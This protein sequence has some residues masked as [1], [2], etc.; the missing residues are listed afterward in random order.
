MSDPSTA[1][2]DAAEADRVRGRWRSTS[3]LPIIGGTLL[4]LAISLGFLI[5]TPSLIGPDEPFH[6]DRVVA[7]AHGDL[8]QDA[9]ELHVSQGDK[10]S[11]AA[12]ARTQ[13]TRGAPSWAEYRP[14]PRDQ[15]QSLNDLGGNS[16]PTLNRTNYLT[17][18][19]P[20]YYDLLGGVMWLLP[21]ADGMAV[22]QL[23]LLL[24]MVNVLIILALPALFW[25]AAKELFGAGPIAAAAAY[26]PALIP[27]IPRI[28]AT[29]NND[30][31]CIVVGAAIIWLCLRVMRGDRT[32]RTAA[33]LAALAVVGSLTKLTVM[34]VVL[35]IV[36][37]YLVRWIRD[38]RLPSW[39]TL[40]ALTIGG[41]VSCVWW[42]RNL[43]KFGRLVP[44]SQAWG[45]QLAVTVSTPRGPDNPADLG[46]FWAQM[47]KQVPLRFWGSLG[48]LEPPQLPW[49][50]LLTLCAVALASAAI[51]ITVSRGSR[52]E[53]T[54]GWALGILVIAL[55]V[56][57]SL[58]GYLQY[59][60][61][62][63]IQGRYIYPAALGLLLPIA[64]SLVW[65]LR[66]RA[67][68]A[69]LVMAIVVSV[70]DGWALDLSLAHPWLHRG[71]TLTPGTV[72]RALAT[73]GSHF[74][75]GAPVV[76]G[77]MLAA[78]AGWIGS[79]VA[80]FH[81]SI[82]WSTGR[83]IEHTRSTPTAVTQEPH[84][85]D[86]GPASVHRP[87]EPS[88]APPAETREQERHESR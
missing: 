18:H 36:V 20:L 62:T 24:R 28:A 52:V 9:G 82:H 17:Q 41:G 10:L 88:A 13:M 12:Y 1:P 23:V 80:A 83:R 79:M 25:A 58:E 26:L 78:A 70:I 48:L 7:A 47:T 14:Y 71:E 21:D 57:N 39:S 46:Y 5:V 4:L 75:F 56:K 86:F 65:A 87:D 59:P 54:I 34:I 50:I 69:P 55:M 16:R 32:T 61:L 15:R 8:I 43:A 35:L 74:P 68:W 76:V 22:D 84:R 49:P 45:T 27:G 29:I 60:A 38:R 81:W 67:N 77:L 72:G 31:L 19:P 85:I 11:T 42:V 63:G 6:F 73:L 53:V 64:I 37:A 33:W 3:K 40:A 2:S 44:E 66:R 51:A 30:N